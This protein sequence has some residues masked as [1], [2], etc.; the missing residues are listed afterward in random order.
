LNHLSLWAIK[1]LSVESDYP[2]VN[3]NKPEL[4]HIVSVVF[5]RFSRA[6]VVCLLQAQFNSAAKSGKSGGQKMVE[7]ENT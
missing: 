2:A 1:D 4:I 5:D 7:G 3:K 6:F